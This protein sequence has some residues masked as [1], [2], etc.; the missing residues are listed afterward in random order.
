[1][2]VLDFGHIIRVVSSIMNSLKQLVGDVKWFG[3][4]LGRKCD[5]IFKKLSAMESRQCHDSMS[6]SDAVR[7]MELEF[8]DWMPEIS[9]DYFHR[10]FQYFMWKLH[11]VR[12]GLRLATNDQLQG[13]FLAV[14]LVY[15]LKQQQHRDRWGIITNKLQIMSQHNDFFKDLE[16]LH[17]PEQLFQHLLTIEAKMREAGIAYAAVG[18]RPYFFPGVGT[19][20]RG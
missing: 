11:C 5:I 12:K 17:T 13:E 16:D 4:E 14:H 3:D 20:T 10:Q 2:A 18:D 8:K 6:E 1:M 7:L 19:P 9:K 15:K